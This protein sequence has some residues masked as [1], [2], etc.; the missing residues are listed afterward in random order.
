MDAEMIFICNPTK[1]CLNYWV[2]LTLD[3]GGRGGGMSVDIY[4]AC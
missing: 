4:P 2:T 1:P 3:L